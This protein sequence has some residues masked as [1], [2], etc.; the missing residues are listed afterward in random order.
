MRSSSFSVARVAVVAHIDSDL[1]SQLGRRSRAA[2][3]S[4]RA[5]TIRAALRLRKA[6]GTPPDR[7]GRRRRPEPCGTTSRDESRNTTSA[8][9]PVRSRTNI[10]TKQRRRSGGAASMCTSLRKGYP[11]AWR[12]NSS[13][14]EREGLLPLTPA[15]GDGSAPACRQRREAKSERARRQAERGTSR[16]Y[17]QRPRAAGHGDRAA[18]RERSED[19]EPVGFNRTRVTVLPTRRASLPAARRSTDDTPTASEGTDRRGHQHDRRRACTSSRRT[20]R[21][22]RSAQRTTVRSKTTSRPA[23][24]ATRVDGRRDRRP[25]GTQKRS[26]SPHH[27]NCSECRPPSRTNAGGAPEA[28]RHEQI[29]RAGRISAPAGGTAFTIGARRQRSD[30]RSR[31]VRPQN[32][33]PVKRLAVRDWG[34]YSG[35]CRRKTSTRL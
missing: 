1:W 31:R 33:P 21:S 25:V 18:A 15:G 12:G 34:G 14:G 26:E 23:L 20:R 8:A 10:R 2:G 16:K 7:G 29:E 9:R 6:E 5:R 24:P 13:V 27:V 19:V 22:S 11:V 4:T 3:D 32:A 28:G 35:G 30:V 17:K